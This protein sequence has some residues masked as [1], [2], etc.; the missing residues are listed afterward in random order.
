MILYLQNLTHSLRLSSKVKER[1]K[2]IIVEVKK[3][4]D[5]HPVGEI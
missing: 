4:G 1:N 2:P 5:L 3:E